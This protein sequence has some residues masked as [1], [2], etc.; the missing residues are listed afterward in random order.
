MIVIVIAMITDKAALGRV[1]PVYWTAG[2][3]L[4]AEAAAEVVLFD[5]PAWRLAA[6]FAGWAFPILAAGAGNEPARFCLVG[7]A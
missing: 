7:A 1:H 3:F 4:V 5:T 2:A 6:H